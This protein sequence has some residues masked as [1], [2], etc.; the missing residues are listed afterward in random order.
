MAQEIMCL[1]CGWESKG[2]I[3][4]AGSL[5]CPWCG[6]HAVRDFTAANSNDTPRDAL[7]EARAAFKDISEL[8]GIYQRR[9][10]AFQHVLLGIAEGTL[11]RQDAANLIGA[12]NVELKG[13][14]TKHQ[15][16]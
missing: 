13:W 11:S 3:A 4:A 7:E 6:G 16:N 2:D 9:D 10:T 1:K 12:A 15:P 14:V 8:L 5:Q